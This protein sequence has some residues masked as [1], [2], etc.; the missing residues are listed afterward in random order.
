VKI[1]LPKCFPPEKLPKLGPLPLID[2]PKIP[3]IPQWTI[4][5]TNVS[6]SGE[7]SLS[8]TMPRVV[9]G[10]ATVRSGS[11]Q[12]SSLQA[13]KEDVEQYGTKSRQGV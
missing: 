13:P 12:K 4:F 9:E 6:P 8:P 7:R 2:L 1:D 11:R 10:S 3:L 5:Q